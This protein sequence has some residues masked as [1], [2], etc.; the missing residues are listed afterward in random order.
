MPCVLITAMTIIIV[1]MHQVYLYND[2]HPLPCKAGQRQGSQHSFE[3][4]KQALPQPKIFSFFLLPKSDCRLDFKGE[5]DG[6][7]TSLLI[8]L[9][10]LSIPC[11][12]AAS[13]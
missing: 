12:T 4:T 13:P 10:H 5:L 1:K 8:I 6:I 7:L 3:C 2:G 11:Q 9:K